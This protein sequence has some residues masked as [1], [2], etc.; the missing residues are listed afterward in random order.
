MLNQKPA[1]FNQ[2]VRR[3]ADNQPQI[4]QAIAPGYQGRGRFESNVPFLKVAVAIGDLG[5]I[6]DNQIKPL[7]LQPQ[8]PGTLDHG[9]VQAKGNGVFTGQCHCLGLGI[10]GRYSPAHVLTGESQGNGARPC[11]QIQHT[12]LRW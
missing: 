7:W 4:I 2:P 8:K 12:G 5:W 10:T 6:G 11:S 1:A 3:L 9:K